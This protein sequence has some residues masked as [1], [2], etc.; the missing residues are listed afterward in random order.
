MMRFQPQGLLGEN[1]FLMN[2]FNQYINP[3]LKRKGGEFNA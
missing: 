3:L 2:K 1:S